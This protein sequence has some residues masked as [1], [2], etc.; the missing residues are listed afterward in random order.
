MCTFMCCSI[1]I[2][3]FICSFICYSIGTAVLI[4]SFVCDS[5]GSDVLI[6]SF[7]CCSI[8]SVVLICSFICCSMGSAVL[9]CSFICC[10]IGSAAFTCTFICCSVGSVVFACTYRICCYMGEC[11]TFPSICFLPVVYVFS[12]AQGEG[13]EGGQL[14][15]QLVR[16]SARNVRTPARLAEE[17]LPIVS[18]DG[19]S[20]ASGDDGLH[21]QIV[22][23]QE[24]S[25]SGFGVYASVYVECQSSQSPS[26][27]T[28]M[29]K[30]MDLHRRRC[31]AP[32]RVFPP[33]P[34]HGDS[35]RGTLSTGTW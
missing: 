29:A 24:Q 16:R 6:C 34:C 10:P 17:A 33:H 27:F 8:G 30:A 25:Y 5:I 12:H 1:G 9:I 3:V 32:L 4:C 13:Q 21:P 19:S 11:V 15:E 35:C 26:W 20:D 14:R 18:V 23:L 22:E 28:Y 7:I 2:A 31:V